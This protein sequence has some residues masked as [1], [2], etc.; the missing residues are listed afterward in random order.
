MKLVAESLEQIFKTGEFNLPPFHYKKS[1]DTEEASMYY[2]DTYREGKYRVSFFE[3]SK[4]HNGE[5]NTWV[6]ELAAGEGADYVFD[7]REIFQ[8][9]KTVSN[10]IAEFIEEK[11]PLNIKFSFSKNIAKTRRNKLYKNI[12][13]E[14]L[15]Q[16][17]KIK[18]N[19]MGE[20]IIS[21]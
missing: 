7:G 10:I 18:I 21:R 12:I 20:F 6:G 13:E 4:F 2:F 8:I 5:E 3:L 14:N 19:L 11:Q 17:Y 1:K 16:N 9:V 15:P